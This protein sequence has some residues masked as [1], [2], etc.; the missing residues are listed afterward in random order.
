MSE[1]TLDAARYVIKTQQERIKQLE[2]QVKQLEGM[3]RMAEVGR[4]SE[5]KARL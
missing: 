3:L 2:E 4:L 5:K 1:A